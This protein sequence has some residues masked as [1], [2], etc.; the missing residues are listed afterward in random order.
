MPALA[1]LACLFVDERDHHRQRTG[2]WLTVRLALP[3]ALAARRRGTGEHDIVGSAPEKSCPR[4]R[5]CTLSSTPGMG[6]PGRATRS[7]PAPLCAQRWPPTALVVV[8][9]PRPAGAAVAVGIAGLPSTCSSSR[10]PWSPSGQARS[11]PPQPTSAR[12]F[13]LAC[14]LAGSRPTAR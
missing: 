5:A 8:V 7:R 3:S 10:C 4:R 2:I 11:K 12:S 6:R 9:E 13:G 14:W 1:D